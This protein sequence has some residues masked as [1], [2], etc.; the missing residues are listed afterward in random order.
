VYLC[1]MN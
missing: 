1:R